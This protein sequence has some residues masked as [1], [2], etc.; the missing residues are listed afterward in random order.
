MKRDFI[1]LGEFSYV[2]ALQSIGLR[3]EIENNFFLENSEQTK[4]GEPLV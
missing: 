2:F 1:V 3:I 4:N